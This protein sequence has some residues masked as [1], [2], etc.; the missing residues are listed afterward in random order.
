[1][2]RGKAQHGR[3]RSPKGHGA[4]ECQID[5]GIGRDT[6]TV[7]NGW[8]TRTPMHP[9]QLPACKE[10]ELICISASSPGTRA[11]QGFKSEFQQKLCSSGARAQLTAKSTS[12][13]LNSRTEAAS[14]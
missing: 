14:L 11:E 4:D 1:M 7:S 8:P 12:S 6:L 2:E 13:R 3:T 10:K 9:P 5:M